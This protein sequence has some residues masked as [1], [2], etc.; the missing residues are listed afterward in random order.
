MNK[1]KYICP[2]CGY[3]ELDEPAYG[4]NGEPSYNICP[5]CCFEYGVDDSCGYK[6]LEEDFND[7][8]GEWIKEGCQWFQV[9][10]KP[11]NWNPLKQ[12]Q[13][14]N[15]SQKQIESYFSEKHKFE[16][17]I[18]KFFTDK[19]PE[20]EDFM[21]LTTWSHSYFDEAG[22]YIVI[23]DINRYFENCIKNGYFDKAETFLKI[24]WEF[25]KKFQDEY[26]KLERSDT[27]QN[28]TRVELFETI[29][30]FDEK[31]KEKVVELLPEELKQD[32]LSIQ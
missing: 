23:A 22:M 8:R 30:T 4:E 20:I 14:L 12:L 5:C 13:N 2:I 19:I 26:H 3:D 27:M 24:Y 18:I 28:L 15:L 29:D 16:N 9:D 1:Q 32:Y 17:R 7:Y 31:T 21:S 11:K 6:S 10:K 25:Y